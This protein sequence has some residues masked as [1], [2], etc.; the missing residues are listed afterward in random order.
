MKISIIKIFTVILIVAL[1]S[2]IWYMKELNNT[3]NELIS[4]LK[5]EKT[6]LESQLFDAVKRKK[7]FESTLMKV[8]DE[9]RQLRL[10]AAEN[11]NKI[12]EL[13]LSVKE[14]NSDLRESRSLLSKKDKK[15]KELLEKYKNLSESHLKNV[16]MSALQ[17]VLTTEEG[18]QEAPRQ[19]EEPK[20]EIEPEEAEDEDIVA[21]APITVK[22]EGERRE[23]YILEVNDEY[24][25]IVIDAGFD[26]GLQ[27]DDVVYIHDGERVY[28]QA[29]IE[30][31]S[32]AASVAAFPREYM[33]GS[34]KENFNV[35]FFVS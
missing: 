10:A 3:S 5:V 29:V 19:L 35:V 12:W 20:E 30:E 14:L 18:K 27:I 26:A 34:I 24:G 2:G 28:C 1:A 32:E 13:S 16:N 4:S 33:R 25:F 9:R 6:S 23:S 8:R 17:T 11:E 7:E 21:L 22:G 15:I 31:T